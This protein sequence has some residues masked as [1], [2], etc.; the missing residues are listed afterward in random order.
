MRDS[1]G[2]LVYLLIG[3]YQLYVVLPLVYILG[4]LR[5]GISSNA[6]D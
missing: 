3:L 2:L 6:K 1:T 5:L 4:I